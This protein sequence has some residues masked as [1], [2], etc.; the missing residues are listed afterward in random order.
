MSPGEVIALEC[1]A[2]SAWD[3]YVRTVRRGGDDQEREAAFAC[4]VSAEANLAIAR[5]HRWP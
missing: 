2:V 1:D 5:G 3:A 4:A